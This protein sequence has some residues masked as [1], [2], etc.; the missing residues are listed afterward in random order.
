LSGPKPIRW[1][2]GK[3]RFDNGRKAGY[4]SSTVTKM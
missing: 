2:T 3:A 1:G 4:R